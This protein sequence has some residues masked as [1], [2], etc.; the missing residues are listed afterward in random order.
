MT[1]TETTEY[2]VTL[3]RVI[4]GEWVKLRGQRSI[5]W[6]IALAVVVPLLAI[7]IWA[8]TQSPASP[9]RFDEVDVVLGSVTSSIFETL[10]LFTLLGALVG[11]N[12]YETRTITTTMAAIPRRWPVV[13]AKAVVVAAISAAVS[14]IVLFSGLGIASLIV[15]TSAPVGL[16]DPGVVAALLGTALFQTSAAVISLAIALVLRS[17]IGAIA[18]TFGFLYV[19]PGVF[20]ILPLTPVQFFASTFPGPASGSLTA[21]VDAP[22]QLPYGASVVAV[23]VWTVVW[24]GIALLT[25]EKRDV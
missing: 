24:F 15:P 14:L 5:R 3:P 22:G 13:V 12:E 2:R 16:A 10:V 6:V 9:R 8:L 20:N 25:T 19:V 1:G 11:T 7:A 18:G 17:S 4:R 21:L 23:L